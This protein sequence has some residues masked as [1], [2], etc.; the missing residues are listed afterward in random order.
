MKVIVFR[1]V[2][3]TIAKQNSQDKSSRHDATES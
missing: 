1:C 3:D 2:V